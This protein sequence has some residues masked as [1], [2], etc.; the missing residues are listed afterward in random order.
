MLKVREN[1]GSDREWKDKNV[2]NDLRSLLE[3]LQSARGNLRTDGAIDPTS[4]LVVS[5]VAFLEHS[6]MNLLEYRPV[7]VRVRLESEYLLWFNDIAD[8]RLSN[9][10][11]S[12]ANSAAVRHSQLMKE[13]AE[14][15]VG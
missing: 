13:A 11:Q 2:L 15:P 4:A 3:R 5:S 6:L 10:A 9:S 12:Y 7:D 14:S 1:F 8:P